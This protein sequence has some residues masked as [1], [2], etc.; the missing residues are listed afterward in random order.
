MILCTRIA[1][2]RCGEDYIAILGRHKC[3]DTGVD[4]SVSSFLNNIL[5]CL[6]L[7]LSERDLL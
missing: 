2:M 1:S 6:G 4:F 7:A 5:H 3:L